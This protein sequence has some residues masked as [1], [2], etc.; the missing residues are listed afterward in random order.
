MCV[1]VSVHTSVFVI[2]W[3]KQ[4][5]RGS[6]TFQRPSLRW[7]RGQ[8]QREWQRRDKKTTGGI[9]LRLG[10]SVSKVP[11]GQAHKVSLF[12]PI[13]SSFSDDHSSIYNHANTH[14][15]WRPLLAPLRWWLGASAFTPLIEPCTHNTLLQV[16]VQVLV[17]TMYLN[18]DSNVHEGTHPCEWT[19]TDVDRRWKYAAAPRDTFRF[20]KPLTLSVVTTQ[21]LPIP[22]S[23]P[24]RLWMG[25]DCVMTGDSLARLPLCGS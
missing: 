5:K 16:R 4:R 10:K 13:I 3:K 22:L 19:H 14:T 25:S 18:V 17:Q 6:I 24:L 9:Q 8:T 2:G 21:K 1:C 12:H 7:K 15:R 23:S 11:H 20:N